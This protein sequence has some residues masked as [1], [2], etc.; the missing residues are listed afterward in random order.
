MKG[1][2]EKRAGVSRR[3]TLAESF[4]ARD[5]RVSWPARSLALLVAAHGPGPVDLVPDFIPIPGCLAARA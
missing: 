3:Q 5:P 2:L 4:V 1:L